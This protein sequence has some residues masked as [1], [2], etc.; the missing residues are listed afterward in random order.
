M[1]LLMLCVLLPHLGKLNVGWTNPIDTFCK[2]LTIYAALIESKSC[3]N[4]GTTLSVA[5]DIYRIGA[6]M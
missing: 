6:S 4:F 5:A 2:K 1:T 3:Y